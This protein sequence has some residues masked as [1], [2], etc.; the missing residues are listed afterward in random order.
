M[1]RV[2]IL[3]RIRMIP[4]VFKFVLIW[5]GLNDFLKTVPNLKEKY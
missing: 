4:P 5:P 2:K 3:A 1:I